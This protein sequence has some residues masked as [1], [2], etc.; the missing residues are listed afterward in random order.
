MP[1]SAMNGVTVILKRPL[2]RALDSLAV[3]VVSACSHKTLS[4]KR[5]RLILTTPWRNAST[6][7]PSR[8]SKPKSYFPRAV[9]QPFNNFRPAFLSCTRYAP[10]YNLLNR[11]RIRQ[12]Y[13]VGHDAAPPSA[14]GEMTE[15]W[16]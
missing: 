12:R 6:P 1:P 8:I 4:G 13:G 15:T 2:S 11:T 16:P 14:N 3:I 9:D 5:F 10:Q 7:T